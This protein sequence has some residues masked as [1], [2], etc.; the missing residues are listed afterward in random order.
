MLAWFGT[1]MVKG[2]AITL[3]L[4]IGVSMF[5]AITIT[6]NLLRIVEPRIRNKWLMG[7][8]NLPPE[9]K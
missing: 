9:I 4:G 5:S 2:F 1:S 8:T 7:G 6:R 3:A